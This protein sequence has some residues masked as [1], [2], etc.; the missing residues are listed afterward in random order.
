MLVGELEN[1]GFIGQLVIRDGVL[2]ND[3]VFVFDLDRNGIVGNQGFAFFEDACHFSGFDAV[4]VIF[5]DPDL[6]LAGVGFAFCAAAIEKRFLHVADL[7]DVEGQRYGIAFRK[8]DAEIPIRMRG[9]QGF[10]FGKF[11][12]LIGLTFQRFGEFHRTGAA[13][14]LAICEPGLGFFHV[15]CVVG[16]VGKGRDD[17]GEQRKM[18][19]V[20]AEVS[21]LS[22]LLTLQHTG[23]ADDLHVAGN[24]G[25][26]HFQN[27]RELADAKRSVFHESDYSPAGL[28]GKGAEE[29]RGGI[30]RD[31]K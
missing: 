23:L 15:G 12:D 8:A 24:G 31:E 16:A 27:I 4:V 17:F 11:H 3:A 29:G 5:A 14:V 25:L 22:A 9:E 30:H 7:G 10:E 2:R 6:K 1:D 21:P 19:F 28:V 13:R 26:R 20:D 18:Y